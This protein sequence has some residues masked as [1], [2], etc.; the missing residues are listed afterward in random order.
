MWALQG[1]L[2]HW[3][4][5]ARS[6]PETCFCTEPHR[7]RVRSIHADARLAPKAKSAVVPRLPSVEARSP[8]TKVMALPC[9][10]TVVRTSTSPPAAP[11]ND[12]W[13]DRNLVGCANG[14]MGGR[15]RTAR[16]RLCVREREREEGKDWE[17]ERE[18]TRP[19]SGDAMMWNVQK[20]T[21]GARE[22]REEGRVGCRHVN[23]VRGE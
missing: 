1:V 23:V 13:A 17:R 3:A 11:T 8:R 7:R 4:G 16:R 6:S 18:S 22:R 19:R 9:R 20:E 14:G 15:D 10:I 21:C 12:T 2:F 5:C